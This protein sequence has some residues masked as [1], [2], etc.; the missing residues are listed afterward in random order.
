M[1][2]KRRIQAF[3][4]GR[5]SPRATPESLELPQEIELKLAIDPRDVPTLRKSWILR[6]LSL[7]HTPRRSLLSVYYDTPSLSLARRGIMLRVRKIGREHVQCVKI[8]IAATGVFQRVELESPIHGNEPDLMR[9]ADPGIRR[10]IQK[11]CAANGLARAFATKVRR[12]TWLLQIGRSQIECAIDRGLIVSQRKRAPISEIELELKSGQ[13]ARLYQLAHRL[14]A[15]VPLRIETKSKAARGYDLI[16]HTKCGAPSAAPILLNP[17]MS[18]RECFA[19]I[20]QPCVSYVLTSADFADKSNDPEG[21]HRLRVAIRR[22]RALLSIFHRAMRKGCRTALSVELRRFERKLSAAR[23]WDVL[24]EGTIASMPSS[25]RKQRSTEQLVRIAQ[26]KRD[27][28]DKSAHAALQDP[29]YTDILLRLAFWADSQFG[30]NA[31]LPQAGR[32]K[33]HLLADPASAFA[34]QVIGVYDDRVR[35]LGRKVRKLNPLDLHRL[36]IRV[37]KLDYAT[38]FF[39]GLWPNQRTRRYLTALRGLEDALGVFHDATVA[40]GLLAHFTSVEGVGAQLSIAPVSR[41]LAQHLRNCRR[42]A[43]ELWRE[44]ADQR[45]FWDNA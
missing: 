19:A 20:A 18:V 11:R 8:G 27:E 9:I 36:R 12:E 45:S 33:P 21:I 31:S 37:K 15:I 34:A 40:A 38:E 4:K 42:E 24:V 25:L 23:D 3:K 30:S 32:W 10:L 6:D 22:M 43:I 14:N 2:S 28:G 29:R 5:A 7:K 44:F 13:P 41:W 39:D 26:A 1:I 16:Q 35:T 17:A